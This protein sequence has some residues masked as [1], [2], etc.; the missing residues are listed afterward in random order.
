VAGAAAGLAAAAALVLVVRLAG[1]DL[2][3]RVFGPRSVRPELQELIAA[4]ANEPTR[5][6]EG[7]LSA[8]FTYAPAPSP[9]RGPGDREVSA[10]VRIAAAK[11]EELARADAAPERLAALG[12]AY[13]AVGDLELGIMSLEDA[14]AARPSD[15][16][17]LNDLAAAYLSRARRG[18][19]AEDLSQ[20]ASAADRAIRAAP[21]MLEPRFNRALA[22]DLLGPPSAAAAAWD[23]Y[24]G[25]DSRSPWAEEARRHVRALRLEPRVSFSRWTSG[26]PVLADASVEESMEQLAR[27]SP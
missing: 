25:V 15:P 17:I 4:V 12:V 16:S 27:T 1:P 7:R 9:T 5:P 19:R 10:A 23:D 21:L 3:D 18:G 13:L 26:A 22:F 8:G 20:A 11:I 24:L 14:A 6:I 2:L